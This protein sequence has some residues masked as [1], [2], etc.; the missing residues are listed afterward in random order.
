MIGFLELTSA[1]IIFENFPVVLLRLLR[2]LRVFRLAKTLPRLRSIVEALISGFSAVGWICLLIVVFNY[3]AACMCMLIFRDNDP[4]HWGSVGRSMFTMLRLE[5]LD[6]LD[7]ILYITVYGCDEYPAGYGGFTINNP[8]SLCRHP[9][10]YGWFGALI[11]FVL[12]IFGA[13][14]LPTVLIGIVSLKFDEASQKAAK[15]AKSK[16]ETARIVESA[17][18]VLPDFFD[19][20][21]LFALQ[22]LFG[23]LD[24]QSRHELTLAE[25]LPFYYYS[26]DLLFGVALTKE[27]VSDLFGI[28]DANRDGYIGYDEYMQFVGVLKSIELKCKQSPAFAEE[29]FGSDFRSTKNS[30]EGVSFWNNA[31][32]RSD[33]DSIQEAWEIIIEAV[34]G[35][36]GKTTDEKASNLFKNMDSDRTGEL[37]SDELREGF[38]NCNINLTKRQNH[39]FVLALDGDGNGS[40]STAEFKTILLEKMTETAIVNEEEHDVH[41]VSAMARRAGDIAKRTFVFSEAAK[42]VEKEVNLGEDMTTLAG[43]EKDAAAASTMSELKNKLNVLPPEMVEM[44]N[45]FFGEDFGGD[46]PLAVGADLAEVERDAE[47]NLARAL[48]AVSAA[49]KV[50]QRASAEADKATAVA[51][52]ASAARLVGTRGTSVG[53][54]LVL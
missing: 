3:I 47:A 50:L 29:A 53:R 15:Y 41:E 34:K 45:L 26:F 21:R 52:K 12:V 36:E 32:A 24:T 2:L 5:T 19:S 13:F 33:E 4:F 30:R 23:F 1:K 8:A 35:A 22:T 39:A 16:I 49:Q 40:I 25:L 11:L 46:N 14:V 54:G 17:K 43:E 20:D 44:R 10:A 42:K 31:M 9:R 38:K 7:Q 27:Q 37:D 18:A 28:A 48:A 51:K 6:N